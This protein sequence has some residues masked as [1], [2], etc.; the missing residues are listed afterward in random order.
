MGNG[1]GQ[2]KD[3]VKLLIQGQRFQG[4][5]QHRA[6]HPLD[7]IIVFQLFLNLFA[8]RDV[9]DRGRGHRFIV[10]LQTAETDISRKIRAVFAQTV[11]FINQAHGPGTG[12]LKIM[13]QKP[14]M[15]VAETFRDQTA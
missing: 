13:G 15:L 14:L 4:D 9:P 11:D 12:L 8:F 2:I 10:H 7:M 1:Q 3:A 5:F 6:G